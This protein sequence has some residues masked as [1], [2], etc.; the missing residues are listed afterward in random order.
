[1][2]INKIRMYRKTLLDQIHSE[3]QL[4]NFSYSMESRTILFK[5]THPRAYD[6]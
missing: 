6:V 4:N 3:P 5:L 1:M 2:R